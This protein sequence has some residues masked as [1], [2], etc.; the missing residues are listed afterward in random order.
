MHEV[1]LHVAT[2]AHDEAPGCDPKVDDNG[3][4]SDDDVLRAQS[5]HAR[6]IATQEE[7]P[8][9]VVEPELVDALEAGSWHDHGE[10]AA[11]EHARATPAASVL[12]KLCGQPVQLVG[13]RVDVEVREL[14][15]ERQHFVDPRHADV[16]S[17]DDEVGEVDEHVFQVGNGPPPLRRAQR[18]GVPDLGAEGQTRFDARSVHRVEA[19]VVWRQ[20]PQPRQQPNAAETTLGAPTDLAHRLHRRAQVDRAD[21]GEPIGGLRDDLGD[22]VV[23]EQPSAGT[24]PRGDKGAVDAPSVEGA[25]GEAEWHVGDVVADA[26][27][28][29]ERLEHGVRDPLGGGVLDPGVDDHDC[30]RIRGTLSVSDQGRCG[31]ARRVARGRQ[32]RQSACLTVALGVARSAAT[33]P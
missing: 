7:R 5:E 15:G 4:A 16:S 6:G 29:A 12:D 10:V 22:V 9:L 17:D 24:A 2:F 19:P 1:T 18:S 14:V 32:A 26:H 13:G 31:K 23:R 8:R 20:I 27:P 11:E 33:H 30:V 3:A 25:K 21:A 28:A